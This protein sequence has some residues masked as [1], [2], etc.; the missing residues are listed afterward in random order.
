MA[1]WVGSSSA[2]RR[3]KKLAISSS[4]PA[5]RTWT[6]SISRAIIAP[7]CS[8]SVSRRPLRAVIFD[9]VSSRIRAISAL[10]HSRTAATSSSAWRRSVFASVAERSWICST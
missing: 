10:D 5:T 4:N 9:S 7:C 1:K 3:S 8:I 2:S 6:S